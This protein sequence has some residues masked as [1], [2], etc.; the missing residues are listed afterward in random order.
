M[1]FRHQKHFQRRCNVK[2]YVLISIVLSFTNLISQNKNLEIA[3]DAFL[4]ALPLSVF[5]ATIINNDKI[6]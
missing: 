3:G 6:G 5:T 1:N 2:T 4:V